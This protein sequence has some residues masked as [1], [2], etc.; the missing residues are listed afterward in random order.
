MSNNVDLTPSDGT[1]EH[2]EECLDFI[3][4]THLAINRKFSDKDFDNCLINLS[5]HSLRLYCLQ[6]NDPEKLA[7]EL[8]DS[9][10]DTMKKSIRMIL[11]EEKTKKNSAQTRH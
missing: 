3:K 5:I 4:N 1:G 7:V 11:D 8:L 10:K 9:M 6:F 2:E